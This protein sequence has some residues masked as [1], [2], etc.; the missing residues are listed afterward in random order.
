MSKTKN[1]KFIF[2]T[3]GVVSSVGKGLV[4]ASLATLLEARGFKVSVIKCD[5]Y[6]NVDPGTLSPFQHGEVY[7]TKDGAETDLDLGHYER[8]TNLDLNKNHS[9][10]TGQIYQTVIDKE[11]KGDYLGRTVQVIPHITN[12]IKSRIF[13]GAGQ[14]EITVVEIGGTIGDIEGLPFIEA[15][16]Q[17]RIE[18]GIENTIF[19]HV[20][21]IPFIPS[22]GELKSKPSQHSVKALREVGLQPDFLLCRSA[23]TIN[24]ELKEKLALFSNLSVENIIPVPDAES[25]YEIPLFLN[26]EKL[27]QKLIQRMSLKTTLASLSKWKNIV[28]KIKA[29][30]KETT[31]GLVGKYVHLK[32]SY[33]SIHEALMHGGLAKQ[34]KVNIEYIDS[35]KKLSSKDLKS[36]NGI[37]VPGGFGDRGIDGKLKAI[38][39]CRENSVP[40]FGICLGMQMA[41]IEFAQNVCKIK[42]AGSR[43]SK[44]GKSIQ[45]FIIDV[46]PNQK[47]LTYKGGSMRLG[48]YPCL[49]LKNSKIQKIY[50]KDL[51]EERHR[52]RYEFNFNFTEQFE[53]KGMKVAGVH[54]GYENLVEALEIPKHP[55]FIGVQFHPEFQSK[56]TKPHPLFVSFI[57]TCEKN[58]TT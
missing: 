43:E 26:K 54:K 6:I 16:R 27:D 28:Q 49:L 15:I 5:P 32:D 29:P 18:K 2:I 57:E 4:S 46:M 55:W 25:I 52:H 45:N 12:E 56:P 10:T 8:F 7:V 58:K 31:I 50:K 37:L 35:E 23:Q 21:F 41:A 47:P 40:F 13:K 30:K 38:Q 9:I 53:K 39:Y 14:A 42:G 1:Q 22:A 11:R 34:I 17:I 36:L 24:K 20:T 48:S 3:G 44:N 51:I 19:A 33:Q